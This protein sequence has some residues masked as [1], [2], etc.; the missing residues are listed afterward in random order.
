MTNIEVWSP[1]RLYLDVDG[2]VLTRGKYFDDVEKEVYSDCH[3]SP[4]VCQRLG[5]CGL[6]LVWLTTWEDSIQTAIQTSRALKPLTGGRVLRRNHDEI[7]DHHGLAITWK[8]EALVRDQLAS[9]T[10]FVWV[11]D[12]ITG[13]HIKRVLAS[14]QR[15]QD[16]FEELF[17]SPS[18]DNGLVEGELKMIE[19]FVKS[20]R[21]SV[22]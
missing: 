7:F 8:I 3:V 6:E 11:D 12:Q 14:L 17:I 16:G 22:D 9:P 18:T 13:E 2:V 5:K 1:G 19:G 10:P 15:P 21:V 4:L 20:R